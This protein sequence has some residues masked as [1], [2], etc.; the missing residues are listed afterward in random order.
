MARMLIRSG[1]VSAEVPNSNSTT[2]NKKPGRSTPSKSVP[3]RSHRRSRSAQRVFSDYDALS[4]SL[5]RIGPTG[6]IS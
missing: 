1:M 4:P 2:A 3:P 6:F 5:L